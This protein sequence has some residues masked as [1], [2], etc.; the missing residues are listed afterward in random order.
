MGQQTNAY[1]VLV[2]KTQGKNPLGR[3]RYRWEDNIKM[4]RKKDGVVLDWIYLAQ[5]FENT[6]MKIQ[7]P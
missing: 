7:V 6:V 4:I 5:A 2:G 3:H 1:R